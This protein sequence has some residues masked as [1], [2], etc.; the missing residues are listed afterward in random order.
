MSRVNSSNSVSSVSS[1]D[2]V[3]VRN[4]SSASDGNFLSM[5]A[6]LFRQGCIVGAMHKRNN[7]MR[8]FPKWERRYKR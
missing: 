2:S 5:T 8:V 1:E 4:V 3:S 6:N 7:G